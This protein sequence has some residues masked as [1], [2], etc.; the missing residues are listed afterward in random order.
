MKTLVNLGSGPDGIDGWQNFDWGG[1]PLLMGVLGLGNIS[2][3][4]RILPEYYIRKWP[5]IRLC[6]IR[7]GLPLADNSV[8]WIYCSHVLEHF[9]LWETRKVLAEIK[10]VLKKK[11]RGRLVLPDLGKILTIEKSPGWEDKFCRTMWGYDKD[12]EPMGWWQRWLR[13]QIRG[14]Q[15]AYTGRSMMKEL[16]MVGFGKIEEKRFRRGECPNIDKLDLAGHEKLSFYIEF[17]K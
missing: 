13:K 5:R 16:K 1:L 17:E 14:H 11:G 2:L 6:D 10:R 4:R 3:V 15:W 12:V 9:E 8:D 7:K